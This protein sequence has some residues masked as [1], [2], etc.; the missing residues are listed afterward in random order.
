MAKKTKKRA[1]KELTRKQQSRLERDRRTE[2]ILK[3]S[4]T[5]VTIVVV[6]VLAFGFITEGVIK[7]R[8][9]VAAVGGVPITTSEFQARVRFHRMQMVMNLNQMYVQQ[10]ALNPTDPNAQTY[11]EYIQGQILDLQGQLAE[12][13]ALIIGDQALDQL[14]E[15]ELVH[16][17]TNL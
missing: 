3:W 7:A 2:R 4:V 10:E 9:S 13:N 8:P 5:A 6:G 17:S 12:E 15:E 16:V 14:I 1:P 11:L